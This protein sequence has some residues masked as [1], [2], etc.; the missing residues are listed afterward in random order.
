MQNSL[1]I[2][3]IVA[4]VFLGASGMG[5]NPTATPAPA[6]PPPGQDEQGLLSP[7]LP[8]RPVSFPHIE[9]TGIKPKHLTPTPAPAY[10]PPGDNQTMMTSPYPEPG[11]ELVGISALKDATDLSFPY[12]HSYDAGPSLVLIR[13]RYDN[14]PSYFLP[15]KYPYGLIY[16]WNG[17]WYDGSSIVDHVVEW[18]G[19][20]NQ[21]HWFYS[22]ISD[23]SPGEK[24]CYWVWGYISSSSGADIIIMENDPHP[25]TNYLYLECGFDLYMPFITK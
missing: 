14:P 11:S 4:I 8:P 10:P 23:P 16:K 22:W 5:L 2:Q 21:Y 19:W 6:Y 17:Y 18:D 25:D 12:W 20:G 7:L 9:D 1:I 13:I 3:L 24:E 15:W